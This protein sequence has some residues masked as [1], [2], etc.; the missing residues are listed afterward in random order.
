MYPRWTSLRITFF[1]GSL[2]LIVVCLG[3][4]FIIFYN[5]TR[6]WLNNKRITSKWTLK[7]Q[8]MINQS[9]GIFAM[10]LK[11]PSPP[12]IYPTPQR[13]RRGIA[14]N[15]FGSQPINISFIFVVVSVQT[16]ILADNDYL[17]FLFS[18]SR[19]N[20]KRVY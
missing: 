9:Q 5:D 7:V 1:L 13:F 20:K 8:D 19:D 11:S 18:Y 2:L 16:D 12:D 10:K 4:Y 17:Y 3:Y 15:S 14:E 6:L